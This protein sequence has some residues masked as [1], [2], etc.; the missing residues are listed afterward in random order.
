[1]KHA[2]ISLLIVLFVFFIYETVNAQGF[3]WHTGYFGFFDNREYF[4]QYVND[5]TIFGMRLSGEAG[6]HINETGRIMAGV[7]FLY[8]FGGNGTIKAPDITA[9]YEGYRKHMGLTIGAFPRAKRITMPFALI[10][11]T[12]QYYRPNIEGILLDYK[13]NGFSHNVWIDW[14]G[15]Q[16]L[17]KRE[18]FIIGFS[19]HAEKGIFI[20]NHHFVMSHLAHSLN[21]SIE[22]HIRDNGGYNIMPGLDFSN[23]T[24]FDIFELSVG[25][26]GS[27][28][29][30]RGVYGF[31][32]AHGFMGE[33]KLLYKK[34]GI[35]GIVYSGDNQVITSGDGFYKSDFYSRVD[36]YFQVLTPNIESRVQCSFHFLP[37]ILDLSMSLLLRADIEGLFYN[38]QSN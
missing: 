9:F 16:S 35:N 6:Y 34:I 14:T 22:E 4:N 24:G 19:G 26:L 11:D 8:E 13:T 10:T 29:R 21:D 20:Y 27:Y 5:Q 17:N 32:F 18:A 2:R 31:R 15:R 7:N 30:I 12:F 28:D 23:K 25:Y 37:G 1:M 38:H 33:L 3:I 36:T